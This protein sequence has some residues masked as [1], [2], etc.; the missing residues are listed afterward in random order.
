MITSE[1]VRTLPSELV[2]NMESDLVCSVSKIIHRCVVENLRS[3]PRNASNHAENKKSKPGF[4]LDTPP[5]R[6]AEVVYY[7]KLMLN[8]T[9]YAYP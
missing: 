1:L 2:R 7:T 8:Y 6:R 3:N 9:Y 5:V 4:E